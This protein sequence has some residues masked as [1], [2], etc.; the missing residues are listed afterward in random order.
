MKLL[1]ET[2]LFRQQNDGSH[3]THR[4]LNVP[5]RAQGVVTA[6]TNELTLL[7][8]SDRFLTNPQ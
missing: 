3:T 8:R 1:L 2:A 4:P 6:N 7:A 5:F